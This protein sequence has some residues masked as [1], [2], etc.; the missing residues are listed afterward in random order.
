MIPFG[1]TSCISSPSVMVLCIFAI[2]SSAARILMAAPPAL[3]YGVPSWPRI[4]DK[5]LEI[6]ELRLATTPTQGEAK[7]PGFT[8]N[9][10]YSPSI[11][12]DA[13]IETARISTLNF[14][15]S[16]PIWG[17]NTFPELS[18]TY[19][20]LT[21]EIFPEITARVDA[22]FGEV[23]PRRIKPS[24]RVLTLQRSTRHMSA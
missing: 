8:I 11:P 2:S 14:L 3:R 1:A 6:P 22:A 9:G 18:V 21:A 17:I 5:V 15:F 19:L 7:G 10:T 20:H 16:P 4:D 13:G 23:I 24:R 12:Y